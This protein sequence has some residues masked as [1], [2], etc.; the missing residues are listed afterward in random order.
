M[1]AR[2]INEKSQA[3]TALG[4]S[5]MKLLAVAENYPELKA[6]RNFANFQNE[7]ASIEKSVAAARRFF[8]NSTAEFNS[9][10]QQFPAVI[11]AKLFGFNEE[12]FFD[13]GTDNRS[14]LDVP[15]AVAL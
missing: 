6:D 11:V 1:Q 13:V 3:E 8:N 5:L 12:T 10:I 4:S 2:T 7:L 14:D 15:V 9:A